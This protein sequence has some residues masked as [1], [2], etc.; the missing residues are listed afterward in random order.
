MSIKGSW[1]KYGIFTLDYYI[2]LYVLMCKDV[3]NILLNGKYR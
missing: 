1:I 2:D 3:H